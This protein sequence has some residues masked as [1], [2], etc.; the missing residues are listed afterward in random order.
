M[1]KERNRVRAGEFDGGFE[2]VQR[3]KVVM[4]PHRSPSHGLL[5]S[6]MN[7]FRRNPTKC[8]VLG[9]EVVADS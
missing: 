5:N 2:G 7:S 4:I 9:Q 3:R 6:A 1:K 8:L